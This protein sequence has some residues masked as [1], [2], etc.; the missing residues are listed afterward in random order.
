M[1]VRSVSS[2]RK[3]AKNGVRTNTQQYIQHVPA[4]L[5]VVGTIAVDK[6]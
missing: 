4:V 6:G 1:W 2:N 3:F 5:A